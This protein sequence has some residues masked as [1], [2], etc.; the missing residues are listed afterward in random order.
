M[1]AYQRKMEK[2]FVFKEKKFYWLGYRTCNGKLLRHREIV[3]TQ[4][5]CYKNTY[6][7]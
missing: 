6:G 5:T 1:Q 7:C 3:F 4:N 2:F